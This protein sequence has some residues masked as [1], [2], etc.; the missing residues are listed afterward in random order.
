[1]PLIN[2]DDTI[3]IQVTKNIFHIP[4]EYDGTDDGYDVAELIKIK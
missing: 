2:N 3:Y 4:H 1:M